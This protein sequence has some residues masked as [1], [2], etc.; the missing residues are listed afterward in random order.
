MLKNIINMKANFEYYSLLGQLSSL[1]FAKIFAII[2]QRHRYA[3]ASNYHYLHAAM[4]Q[5]S[6]W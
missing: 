6:V 3:Y 4:K 2:T 5:R 1:F